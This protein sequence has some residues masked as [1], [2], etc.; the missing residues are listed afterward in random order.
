MTAADKVPAPNASEEAKAAPEAPETD[1]VRRLVRWVALLC[2]ALF[3][4]YVA[5][6]HYTPYSDQARVDGYVV[7]IVPEV[8][9]PVIE[10]A[11]E[12]NQLVDAGQLLLKVDP[13]DYQLAVEAAEAS[14]E[15][16]GQD[17]G[18]DTA[19]IAA[20]EARLADAKAQL[21]NQ[22]VQTSRR[23]RLEGLGVASET[24]ADRARAHFKIN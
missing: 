9:G 6:D 19:D 2:A 8:S 15:R 18:A 16:A 10:V 12:I 5:S 13:R 1:P 21:A 11:V 7:P 3:A 4:W 20:A 23:V 14:L 22:R 17:V 24:E